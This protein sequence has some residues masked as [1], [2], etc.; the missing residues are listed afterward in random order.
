[1]RQKTFVKHISCGLKGKF[2]STINN[3]IMKHAHVSLEI[4]VHAKQIVVRVL[5][6]VFVRMVGI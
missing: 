4:I 1:M 3:E 6:H 2:N 5:E